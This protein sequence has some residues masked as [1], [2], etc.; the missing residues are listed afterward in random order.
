MCGLYSVDIEKS[1]CIKT[2]NT[3]VTAFRKQISFAKMIV[4]HFYEIAVLKMMNKDFGFFV[5]FGNFYV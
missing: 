5:I 2:S 1:Q 3:V 4:N